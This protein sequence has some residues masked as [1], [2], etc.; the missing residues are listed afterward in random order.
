LKKKVERRCRSDEKT[1]K[2]TYGFL[3]KVNVRI[4]EI[5]EGST[6]SHFVES[7]L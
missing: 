2:K 6:G 5:G 3:D 7:L 1:R 4:L